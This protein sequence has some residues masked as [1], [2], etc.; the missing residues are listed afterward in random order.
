MNI[1]DQN[2]TIFDQWMNSERGQF[3]YTRQ[4]KLIS[5]LIAPV[6]GEKVLGIGC[7]SGHFL[8]IFQDKKCLVTGMDE[9]A[10]QL[11]LAR[12]RLGERPELILG[13]PEDPP[14]SD[15][16]FDVVTLIY[17]LGTARNPEKAI[18]EAIRVSRG[19]IFI[20]FI[21]Y[22]SLA[23]TRQS[24]K[25]LFGL[26]LSDPFR[27]FSVFE[28]KSKV[29]RLMSDPVIHWGSVIYFP[30]ILYDCFSEI[31]E[32]I[33][34]TNNPFGAFASLVFPVKYTM[35]T[36]QNPVLEQLDL[37]AKASTAAPEAVREMLE[38]HR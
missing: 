2:K 29:T 13:V 12:I 5:D 31:E 19:R 27:S 22:L 16:E 18:A 35:R 9:S 28:M 20:G 8:E 38:E 17:T 14:F 36:I 11:K 15:N 24:L 37:T 23:G 4:K 3:V 7:G 30:G 32:Y 34:R 33:P 1:G 21:N 26:P 25:K 10:D 6:S